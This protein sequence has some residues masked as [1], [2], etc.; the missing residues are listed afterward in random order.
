MCLMQ[1]VVL[2]CLI[3]TD[4]R[5]HV[6]PWRHFRDVNNDDDDVDDDDKQTMVTVTVTVLVTVTAV[7][8]HQVWVRTKHVRL[9]RYP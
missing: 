3:L 1:G 5:S 2:S 8:C 4:L 6:G 7:S 9:I